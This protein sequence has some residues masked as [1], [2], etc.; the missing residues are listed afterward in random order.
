[1]WPC[2]A[3]NNPEVRYEVAVAPASQHETRSFTLKRV[4][5]SEVRVQIVPATEA[6]LRFHE[7]AWKPQLKVS[8]ALDA[9]WEWLDDFL[10]DELPSA[11]RETYALVVE[12]S[13]APEALMSI[14]LQEGTVYVERPSLLRTEKVLREFAAAAL[15]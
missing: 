4:D 12:G 9:G 10:R 6:H 15:R 7:T 14:E 11:S 1:M 13:A 3:K 5:G 8:G 2:V